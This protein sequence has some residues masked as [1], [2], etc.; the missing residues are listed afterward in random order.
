MTMT[1]TDHVSAG[2]ARLG[3]AGISPREA[4]IDAD[5][6]ARALLDWDRARFL[7]GAREAA[8]CWFADRYDEWLAR[9][10]QREPVSLI[11]GR[12]EF[13]GLEFEVTREVLTPRPETEWLVQEALAC[14]SDLYRPGRSSPVVVDVGTGSGCVA[15]SLARDLASARV[16]ATDISR[17]ALLVARRNAVRHSVAGRIGF[18]QGSLLDPIRPPVDL[19]ASNPPYVP[20]ASFDALPPE[21]RNYEPA[22]ALDGGPDGLSVITRLVDQAR[23]A[24]S[25]GGWLVFEFGDGQEAGVR[26]AI[27]DRPGL[28]L[29]RIRDDL[30]GIARTAV[31]RRVR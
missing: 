23:R 6:L 22:A 29:V 17:G 24:L 14:A 18:V 2:R 12:R 1:L 31:V 20:S 21:V 7:A 30:R 5:V 26:A 8:P 10:A 19:V 27:S 3:A 9:R 13:W 4:A 28:E 15:I 16:V 25:P 11:V